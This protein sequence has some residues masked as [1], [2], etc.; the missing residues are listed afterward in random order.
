MPLS[1]LHNKNLEK[2]NRNIFIPSKNALYP[3]SPIQPPY[4]PM[5]LVV[6]VWSMLGSMDMWYGRDAANAAAMKPIPSN[7]HIQ[8]H[9]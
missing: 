1:N 3:S 4:L 8:T 6:A 9:K 5:L 7:T 2:K